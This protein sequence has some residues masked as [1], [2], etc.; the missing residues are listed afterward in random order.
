[1][2]NR[3]SAWFLLAIS[4]LASA[5]TATPPE[6]V[7]GPIV[8]AN[9][10]GED[11]H[12]VW[13]YA[14]PA[15]GRHLIACGGLSHP[16]LNAFYGYVYSSTDAGATWQRTV[17]DDSTAFVSEESCTYGE[18]GVAYFV[19]GES[20]TSTGTPRHEWGHLQLFVSA[21][22]GMS[23]KRAAIRADGWL[24]WTQMAAIPKDQATPASLAI[25]ANAGT[26]KLGH[27][28]EKRP[29]VL[30]ASG[31]A[32]S[33]SGLVAPPIRSFANFGG[34]SV[35]LPDRTALFISGTSNNFRAAKAAHSQLQIFAYSS[36]DRKVQARAVLRKTPAGRL[37]SLWPALVR[38]AGGHFPNRLYAAWVESQRPA[39]VQLWL[40]TSDDNG[41]HWSSRAIWSVGDTR[42]AAC[43]N[44]PSAFPEIRIAVNRDGVLGVLWRQDEQDV[45]FAASNDGGRTFQASKLVAS[46][47]T[48]ALSLDDAV[49]N[50][51]WWLAGN[52]AVRDGKS[53]VKFDDSSH[54]GLG[55]RLTK[56]EG[57]VDF[58]L[59]ADAKN[60]FHA[61]WAGL[62]ADGMHALMTRTIAAAAS[63]AGTDT[64][65]THVSATAACAE[66]SGPLHPPLP[67]PPPPLKL[68]GQQ[69]LTRSFDLQIAHIDYQPAAH[70]VTAEVVLVNKGDR[71]LRGPLALFG[72]GV[73]SDF[74]VPVALNAA[75]AK[76]GQPFW[77]LSLPVDGLPPKAGN[78][79]LKLRFRLDQ[80]QPM[81]TGNAVAMRVRI[82]RK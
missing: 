37:F 7:L 41:Y 69:D 20:D 50:N 30:Q 29:V 57:I 72:V 51:E 10:P 45:L 58:S 44:D 1:M 68:T 56:P 16:Q 31:D 46:H 22:H 40:A 42:K 66:V 8:R 15:D 76:Q 80:F 2:L 12:E 54:L 77:D 47:A 70:I 25:F 13:A 26:D 23:W 49:P 18:T 24:D 63:G 59:A 6:V 67:G 38:D 9:A 35:V 14:D 4:S 11:V 71:L 81:Y 19:A 60:T 34:G 78:Q 17:L 48:G 5:Q 3:L 52:L 53:P 36:S 61:V 39:L 73:H 21:D 28:W 43:P 82:Y 55:V 74:G 65:L 32:Q 64:L 75:G 79:P 33:L 27:W 62:D